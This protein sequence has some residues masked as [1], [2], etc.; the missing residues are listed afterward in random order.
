MNK[1][2]WLRWLDRAVAKT[3]TLRMLLRAML[4]LRMEFVNESGSKAK[5]LG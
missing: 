1:V 2:A 4:R 3:R 5:I